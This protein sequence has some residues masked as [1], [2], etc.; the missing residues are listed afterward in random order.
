MQSVNTEEAARSCLIPSTIP[1]RQIP[2]PYGVKDHLNVIHTFYA[3]K[4][5]K[6]GFCLV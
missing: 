2:E 1:D 4:E 3:E 6:Q 5:D